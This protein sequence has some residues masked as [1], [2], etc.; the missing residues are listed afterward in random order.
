MHLVCDV[1]GGGVVGDNTLEGR[2]RSLESSWIRAN[3]DQIRNGFVTK[4]RVSEQ[5]SVI[6]TRKQFRKKNAR[7]LAETYEDQ[8]ILT[9]S[10]ISYA[11][12]IGHAASREGVGKYG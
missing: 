8:A 9:A 7:W 6:N 5:K 10:G 12:K 1:H 3:F 4:G 2:E 11:T